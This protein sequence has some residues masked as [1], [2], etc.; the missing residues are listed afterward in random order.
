MA[1]NQ[2]VIPKSGSE[3]HGGLILFH[4]VL[5]TKSL[6][7]RDPRSFSLS[8]KKH[9]VHLNVLYSN[10]SEFLLKPSMKLHERKEYTLYDG[11]NKKTFHWTVKNGKGK[12]IEPQMISAPQFVNFES[13]IG[14]GGFHF[15]PQTDYKARFKLISEDGKE[16]AFSEYV[17]FRTPDSFEEKEKLEVLGPRLF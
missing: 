16:S 13:S 12:E 7:N 10:N 6:T 14:C 5:S 2:Y 17:S 4:S 1:D 8:S 3:Y 15:T 11:S 9:K